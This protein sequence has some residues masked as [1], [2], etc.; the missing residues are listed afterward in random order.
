[1]FGFHYSEPKPA[2]APTAATS[3]T[4]NVVP[5]FG[6]P[7]PGTGTDDTGGNFPIFTPSKPKHYHETKK[8]DGDWKPRKGAKV[9]FN[10]EEEVF[11]DAVGTKADRKTASWGQQHLYN[12][13]GLDTHGFS[14][15]HSPSPARGGY[16]S[17]HFD[18]TK[19]GLA[20][21]TENKELNKSGLDMPLD[22]NVADEDK[23]QYFF[24]ALQNINH[25]WKPA[26]RKFGVLPL[27]EYIT[28][29]GQATPFAPARL[30]DGKDYFEYKDGVKI[31]M[32]KGKTC[33]HDMNFEAKLTD[34]FVL[35]FIETGSTA[36]KG[37]KD[38]FY[39]VVSKE[40]CVT[41]IDELLKFCSFP[42]NDELKARAEEFKASAA[43]HTQPASGVDMI[44]PSSSP[45]V[46]GGAVLIP[47]PHVQPIIQPNCPLSAFLELEA[48]RVQMDEERAKKE[49]ARKDKEEERQ[50]RALDQSERM[51]AV[52]EKL[53]NIIDCQAKTIV[54]LSIPQKSPPATRPK[55]PAA[56]SKSPAARLD[57][58]VTDDTALRYKNKMTGQLGTKPSKSSC[59]VTLDD[60][61]KDRSNDNWEP[62]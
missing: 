48:K 47:P 54:S 14:T 50:N 52:Q 8:D 22:Y 27:D 60:G 5:T 24:N 49:D 4:G 57:H 36:L 62:L 1:M 29:L 6:D 30:R 25:A 31:L 3:K 40:F 11:Y 33:L 43:A 21:A 19:A 10:A 17:L 38:C 37:K 58:A 18:M 13:Q 42:K 2:P 44:R 41:K 55:S 32:S 26:Y 9:Q 34:R 46:D 23:E 56:R 39:S 51:I 12:N 45:T 16:E 20:Q 7:L 35:Y 61:T 15:P 53:A 28:R 59:W